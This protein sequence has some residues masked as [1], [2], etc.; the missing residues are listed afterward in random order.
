MAIR[1]PAK[2]CYW[3][4]QPKNGKV[5]TLEELQQIVGGYIEILFF[6]DGRMMV[7][8][9]EGKLEGLPVN[10][11]ATRIAHENHLI[12]ENDCIVGTV[13]LAEPGEID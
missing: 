12:W 1:L 10:M 5:F 7:L 6:K 8:N 13:L 2:G 11:E 4:C 9:E 3:D